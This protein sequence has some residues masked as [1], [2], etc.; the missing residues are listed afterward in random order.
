TADPQAYTTRAKWG[1]LGA[2]LVEALERFHAAHP[3]AP[4]MDMESL[5]SRLSVPMPPRLFRP[6]VERM[7]TAGV[8]KRE[9]SMVRLPGHRVRLGTGEA[10]LAARVEGAIVQAGFTPPDMKE[11]AA[12]LAIATPRLLELV[13]VLEKRGA[14]VRVTN[15]LFY[16]A[17]AFAR[18]RQAL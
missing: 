18:A 9:E 2:L 16:G 12:S 1:R 17:E 5:R 14:I 7:E 6:V 11:L 8:V 3:L 13:S 15:E 4:G 10:E